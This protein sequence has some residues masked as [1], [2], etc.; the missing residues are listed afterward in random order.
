MGQQTT[1]EL[2]FSRLESFGEVSGSQ[3]QAWLDR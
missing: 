3:V 1:D 2:L